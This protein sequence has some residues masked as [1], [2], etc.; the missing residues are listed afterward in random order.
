VKKSWLF[1]MRF[2]HGSTPSTGHRPASDLEK[3]TL[4]LKRLNFVECK[5]DGTL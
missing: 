4:S 5:T 2:I 1:L 3:F